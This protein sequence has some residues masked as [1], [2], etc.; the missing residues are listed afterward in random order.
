MFSWN[1][2]PNT[3]GWTKQ[4]VNEVQINLRG[5][6][7]ETIHERKEGK[8]AWG[9]NDLRKGVNQQNKENIIKLTKFSKIAYLQGGKIN[10][11]QGG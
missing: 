7:E 11:R 2:I 4:K 9:G 5:V 10:Q 6:E 1:R 8:I 3:Q